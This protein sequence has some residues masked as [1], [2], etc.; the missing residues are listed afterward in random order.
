MPFATRSPNTKSFR[1]A[2]AGF[3]MAVALV[4]GVS[5][6]S[7]ALTAQA[8]AAQ[9]L[10]DPSEGFAEVYGP[11]VPLVQPESQDF[12]AAR[13]Q[14]P[15]L[16][17]AIE[18]NRDRDLAGNIILNIGTGLDDRQLQ[19]QGL[20]LRLEGG[21]VPAEQV[22]LFTWFV[23]SL[24]FEFEDW[25]TSR[26]YLMRVREM[27]Y[28]PDQ[29]NPVLL[30]ANTYLEEENPQASVAY[31]M[32]EVEAADAAG[33]PINENWLLN[34]LQT[35]YDYEL[36]D[37]ALAA[38]VILLRDFPSERNWRNTLQ[39]VSQLHDFE[40][41]ERVDLYR[42]MYIRNTLD[43][44]QDTTRF[45]EDLDPRVMSNEVQRILA[46][47][48]E[49]GAFTSSDPYY[50]EVRG[51]VETRAPQDRSGIGTIV[52]EGRNGD[53][54]D[55]LGAGDVLLSLEDYAQAEQLYAL[56]LE[57]GFD[58]NTANTRIGIA[59][60]QQGNYA[61]ALETFA[62]VSGNRTPIARMWTAYATQMMGS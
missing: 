45:I 3:A 43:E 14:I 49:T 8:V 30:I 41:D 26:E 27:G 4:G 13:A 57:R 60:A 7:T 2:V 31:L 9:D 34:A 48:L 22:G 6:G 24:S 53:A 33:T 16:V 35:S 39:I 59:Q 19:R 51:I 38:G 58:A 56:A 20:M 32:S 62:L 37:S 15:A 12:N 18:N 40:T 21:M 55:A 42:L 46:R 23:G 52:S 10:P 5:A 44:R 61:A 17:A 29:G 28:V 11:V 47:G 25:A 54:L 36:T 50:T 1:S